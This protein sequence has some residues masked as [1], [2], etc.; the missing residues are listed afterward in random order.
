LGVFAAEAFPNPF[1]NE[2]QNVRIR[3]TQSRDALVTVEI[4]DFAGDFVARVIDSKP[5]SPSQ[6]SEGITWG[7]T[8]SSG[9]PLANG[10]YLA[11]IQLND[12]GRVRSTEVKIAIRHGSGK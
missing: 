2:G 4:F 8:S 1:D 5:M 11:H 10:G 3:W 7:G 12:G 9:T 6:A